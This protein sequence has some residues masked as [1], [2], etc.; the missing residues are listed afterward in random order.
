MVTLRDVAERAGV[1]PAVVSAAI[2]GGSSNVRMSEAT[3]QRVHEAIR[4]TGYRVNHAA[5]SL[6]TK[7]TGVVSAVVPKLSNPVFEHVIRGIQDEVARDDGVLL[8]ADADWLTP[9]SHLLSRLAGR[10]MT[11]GFLVRRAQLGDDTIDA[12]TQMQVPCV[13][14]AGPDGKHP[15][16]WVDD[17]AGIRCAVSHLL[18]LGHRRIALVG[19]LALPPSHV[20]TRH[21]GFIDAFDAAGIPAPTDLHRPVG[22]G[23]A[24]VRAA[25]SELIQHPDPPTAIVSDNVNAAPAV[26]FALAEAGVRV[27]DE[28]SVVAYHDVAAA[29]SE[30]PPL[31]T[32]RMPLYDVGVQAAGMLRSLIAGQEEAGRIIEGGA[33]LVLRRSTAAA[34]R[35]GRP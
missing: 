9:G 6:R 32:V 20:D 18:E 26:Y 27:P 11:D 13:V 22:Y 34:S 23:H 16:I 10:G 14:L 15:S 7:R 1:S 8:L 19:G 28:M 5:R 35:L 21:L 4:E 33:E 2:S 12:L 3:R 31:T 30:W 24:E 17:R 29:D 25:V